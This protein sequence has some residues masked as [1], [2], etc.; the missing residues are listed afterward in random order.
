MVALWNRATNDHNK[1]PQ[2]FHAAVSFFLFSL[3]NHSRCRLDVCHTSTHG[4]A[5]VWIWNAGLKCTARGSLKML[6]TKNCHLG[7]IAQHCRAISSQLRHVSTIG[8]KLLNSNISP[9]CP[10]NMVNFCSVVAEIRWQLWGTPANFNGFRV[11]A[12]LLHGTLVVGVSQTAALNRGHHL[13]S[14]GQ[15]WRWALAHIS[16]FNLLLIAPTCLLSYIACICSHVLCLILICLT[17]SA[18]GK[19]I[20]W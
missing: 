14:A 17:V 6:H 4:V 15:P 10:H 8:K 1:K 3:P 12:V 11:L 18:E 19:E 2:H 7:T 13:Y 16:S 9:T 20:M 5:L